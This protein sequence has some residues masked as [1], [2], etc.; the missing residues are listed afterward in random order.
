MAR[1]SKAKNKQGVTPPKPVRIWLPSSPSSH[2]D[3]LVD[4]NGNESDSLNTSDSI[5]KEIH[6]FF[7]HLTTSLGSGGGGATAARPGK[8]QWTVVAGFVALEED[9]LDTGEQDMPKQGLKD[10]NQLRTTS[11]SPDSMDRGIRTRNECS[12]DKDPPLILHGP[13]YPPCVKATSTCD[14]K[15]V[16][17]KICSMASGVKCLGVSDSDSP[18]PTGLTGALSG[19][20]SPCTWSERDSQVV[21]MHAEVLAR[22][23]LECLLMRE[24]R[25][26]LKREQILRSTAE[27]PAYNQV[28]GR[29]EDDS[30]K[31]SDDG[32]LVG[33]EAEEEDPEPILLE[34][35]YSPWSRQSTTAAFA[36]TAPE[37]PATGLSR[38]CFRLK[39]SVQLYLYTSHAPCGAASD[40]AHLRRLDAEDEAIYQL[41]S[42]FDTIDTAEAST[43]RN[44]GGDVESKPISS[45]RQSKSLQVPPICKKPSR[46]D[47]PPTTAFS[48]SDKLGRYQWLGFQGGRLS[49]MF[50][51]AEQA[52]PGSQNARKRHQL[53]EETAYVGYPIRLYGLVVGEDFESGCLHKIFGNVAVSKTDDA[54]YSRIRNGVQEVLDQQGESSGRQWLGGLIDNEQCR[55]SKSS[56]LLPYGR[57]ATSD[58]SEKPTL[59]AV[60]AHTDI[61]KLRTL[62]LPLLRDILLPASSSS[63]TPFSVALS[64]HAFSTP[65]AIGPNGRLSGVVRDKRTRQWGDNSVARVA[66]GRMWEA[67]ERLIENYEVCFG[68]L[69]DR[70]VVRSKGGQGWSE[71]SQWMEE[72]GPYAGWHTPH[73]SVVEGCTE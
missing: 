1:R 57:A 59:P 16:N 11:I 12:P 58:S 27:Q 72:R 18:T 67:Y 52:R 2:T 64:Y 69:G 29:P 39:R 30:R 41:L 60:P 33:L 49:K 26:L 21:D 68:D 61:S 14:G 35:V 37:P 4:D 25:V 62:P 48:C 34:L 43:R 65:Q 55:I 24:M 28:T 7:H 50:E 23:E 6:Q 13:S 53:C 51:S 17:L 40:A 10:G 47:A 54:S 32:P 38:P 45:F 20:N 46:A 31:P 9:L 22:R 73:I 8:G 71:A 44:Q 42:R 70:E 36:H 19:P 3:D 5:A 15:W 63:S 66:R 56:L